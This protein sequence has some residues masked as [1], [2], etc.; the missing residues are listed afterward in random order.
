[1]TLKNAVGR[2]M[3][4]WYCYMARFSPNKND[5]NAESS[6][7]DNFVM[8]A[9]TGWIGM[10]VFMFMMVFNEYVFDLWS[11]YLA[12]WPDEYAN[13]NFRD[14]KNPATHIGIVIGLTGVALGKF[15]HMYV[16]SH[17]ITIPNPKN[18]IRNYV[19][20]ILLAFWPYILAFFSLCVHTFIPAIAI[21]ILTVIY[22]YKMKR[23]DHA[24]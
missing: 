3:G 9:L 21:N 19:Q 20:S 10:M 17:K 2:T 15:G 13:G 24:H 12:L 16:K 18:T 23:F 4:N 11:A 1:M 8:F 22:F 7:V 5:P 6:G 14:L